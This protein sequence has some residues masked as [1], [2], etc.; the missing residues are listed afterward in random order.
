MEY[1][2]F[3]CFSVFIYMSACCVSNTLNGGGMGLGL[4]LH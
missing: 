3:F 4:M 1:K 2:F